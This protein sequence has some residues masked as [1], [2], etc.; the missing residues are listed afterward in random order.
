MSSRARLRRA[1][2]VI[3]VPVAGLA[4]APSGPGAHAALAA[5]ITDG[6]VRIAPT[7]ASW[8]VST[9]SG[10][11]GVSQIGIPIFVAVPVGEKFAVDIGTS[12]A[13]SSFTRG[14]VSRS[15][16]GLTDVQL[17]GVWA[18]SDAL[19]LTVGIN[20]PTGQASVDRQNLEL[21]GMI[22]TD[23]LAMPVA[24]YGIGP[25]FTGGLVYGV[26]ASSWNLSGGLSVRQATGFRPFA[27]T[28]T[29]FVPGSEYRVAFNAD[30][31][32]GGGR[33]ALGLSGSAFGGQT[34]G[35]AATSTGSR[36]IVQVAWAGPL[37]EGKPQLLVSAWHLLAAA[38]EFNALPIPAQN[39]S[40]LQAAVGFAVGAATIEPNIE[41]R[42]WSAGTGRTGTLGLLG[43]RSRVPVGDFTIFPGAAFGLGTFGHNLGVSAPFEGNATGFRLTLGMA[44]TF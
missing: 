33:L 27:D 4:T 32:V 18:I 40:N 14:G 28:T 12:F 36:G 21:A 43:V 39:L 25:A 9:D 16:S 38:G 1:L 35:T 26:E 37:G 42:L 41:A 20:A 34:Y 30:R 24:A 44:R 2:S 5:Q 29:R 22:G 8:N 7:A 17:R 23:I 3:L 31:E 15:L 11:V 10:R 6:Q 13:T 19:V